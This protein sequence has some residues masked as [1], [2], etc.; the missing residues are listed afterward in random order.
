MNETI[1]LIIT[2]LLSG[3]IGTLVTNYIYLRNEKRQAKLVVFQQLI[4]NRYDI[5]SPAFT[6]ALNSLFII[7]Y[8]SAKVKNALKNFHE[9][10][11][12]HN[13]TTDVSNQKLLDLFR[14]ICEELKIDPK[15]L[16][17][18]FFLK[19]FKSPQL[20]DIFQAIQKKQ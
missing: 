9:D 11:M 18:N 6:E 7:F 5:G 13:R 17:D 16:G 14:V 1:L 10:A 4:G 19:P 3:L 12:S 20:A 8:D 2:A 15:P